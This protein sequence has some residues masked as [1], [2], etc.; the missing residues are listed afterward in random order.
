M[1]ERELKGVIFD[2]DGVLVNTLDLH[3]YAWERL[4]AELNISFQR[5]DMERFRGIHQRQILEAYINDLDERAIAAC[6]ERKASYYRK[7]LTEAR[8]EI[9]Y[10]PAV[11]LLHQAKTAGLK[12]GLASSSINARY[13]LE[14]VQLEKLFDAIGDGNTVCRSKP[15]PDIFVWVAGNL[16]LHP[17]EIAVVEDGAAG[18]EGAMAA[19]MY[20]IGINVWGAEPHLNLTMDTLTLQVIQAHYSQTEPVVGTH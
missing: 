8:D 12:I 4:F 10:M 17:R 7:L 2:L 13:V 15:A 5:D 16:G 6:L 18:V 14:L 3:F 1:S 20:V 19:G 11:Q 9:L